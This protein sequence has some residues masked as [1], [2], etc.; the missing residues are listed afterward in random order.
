MNQKKSA[1]TNGGKVN[2]KQNSAAVYTLV[3]FVG[4]FF[5]RLFDCFGVGTGAEEY[6]QLLAGFFRAGV[7][8]A[9]WC[10]F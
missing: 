6:E 5:L 7:C 3:V 2:N 4:T 10:V 8:G 1:A 9:D